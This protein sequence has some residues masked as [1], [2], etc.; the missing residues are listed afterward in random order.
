[1]K[2]TCTAEYYVLVGCRTD[3]GIRIVGSMDEVL[4][5]QRNCWT[6]CLAFRGT[7][8]ECRSF[9]NDRNSAICDDDR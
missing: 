5:E 8:D 2:T 9:I 7:L 3:D 1:M 4:D 6:S